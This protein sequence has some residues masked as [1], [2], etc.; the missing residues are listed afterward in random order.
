MRGPTSRAR[1]PDPELRAKLTPD[2]PVGCKRPLISRDWLPALTRPNVRLVTE[3]ISEIT[4]SGVR[5]TDGE[6][7][8]VDTIVFGTGFRANEYLTAIDI[9]GRGGRRLHDDWREGR[10][11][12]RT[13]RVGVPEPCS[14]STGRTRTA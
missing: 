4:E 10:G 6:E 7:H 1:W 12:P 9:Y 3:P 5:T 11:L 8:A 13:Q 14:C 2:Y